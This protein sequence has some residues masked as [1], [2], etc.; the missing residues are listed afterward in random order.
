MNNTVEL[1]LRGSSAR[2]VVGG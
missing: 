2:S 1:L